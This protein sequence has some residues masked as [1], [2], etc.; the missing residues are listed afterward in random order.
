MK[1]M[2]LFF[3]LL[4]GACGPIPPPV[5]PTPPQ[6][7]AIRAVGGFAVDDHG[8][9]LVGAACR[10]QVTPTDWVA[11]SPSVAPDGYI[12]FTPVP[13]SIRNTHVECAADGYVPLSESRKLTS[14][15]NE[16]LKPLVMRP[17]FVPLPR[18]EVWGQHL[19][20][21]DGVRIT[22]VGTSEFNLMN[23]WQHG[24]DIVPIIKQRVD[25]GF[26]LFRVWTKYALDA[27]NIGTFLDIDYARVPDFL[28]LNALYGAYVEFTAYTSTFDEQPDSVFAP[29]HWTRLVTAVKDSTNVLLELVNENDQ[30]VNWIDTSLYAR[31]PPPTLASHGSNGGEAW[32]VTPYW[33]YA[34]FHSNQAFEE[35]RKVGHNAWEIWNGPTITNETSR[36]PDVGMWRNNEN[37]GRSEQLAC[38]SAKGAALLSA[39][40]VFHSAEG[41]TSVLWAA[42]TL[43]TATAWATCAR[44]VDLSYQNEP[45]RHGSEE[46]ARE[47]ALG[48]LRVYRRGGSPF[49]DIGR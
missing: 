40:S 22:M 27:A 38:D 32:P 13:A 23:R 4:T 45:Y 46:I 5:Q 3:A 48:L 24:E 41:K 18:L 9:G 20:R 42:P 11:G 14:T 34:T 10:L 6:P 8:H 30:A 47:Q 25:A 28:N 21:A 49:A 16:N 35:Q 33:D 2:F 12:L 17:S 15:G 26:N 7:P 36:F 37:P 19:R 1:R 44:A 43:R 31:P 39:G 29:S